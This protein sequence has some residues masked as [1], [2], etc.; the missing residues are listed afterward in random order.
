M[1]QMQEPEAVYPTARMLATL[2]PGGPS[3]RVFWNERV[4]PLMD[5]ANEVPVAS[6]SE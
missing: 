4:Y 5:P 6:R 3:G 1:P 2:P